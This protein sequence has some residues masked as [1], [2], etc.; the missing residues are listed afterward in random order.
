MNRWYTALQ[1]VSVEIRMLFVKAC[2]LLISVAERSKLCIPIVAGE[3][4]Q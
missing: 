4:G 3:K 1:A 2:C